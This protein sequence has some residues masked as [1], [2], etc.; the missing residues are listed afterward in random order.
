M[1]VLSVACLIKIYEEVY[2]EKNSF[3]SSNI[4]NDIMWL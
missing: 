3:I 1:E 2:E 4:N